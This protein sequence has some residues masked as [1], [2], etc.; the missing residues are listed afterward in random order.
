MTLRKV[1]SGD[2]LKI[3]AATFNTF[4]DAARGYSR[5]DAEPRA[6]GKARRQAKRHCP[7]PQHHRRRPD[8][9]KDRAVQ[10]GYTA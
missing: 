5:Q 7:G 2:S 9:H 4:I 8:P 1:K 6:E 10:G 3:P